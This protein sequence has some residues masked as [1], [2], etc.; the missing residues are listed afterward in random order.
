MTWGH[1]GCGGDTSKVAEQL[2]S[3]VQQIFGTSAAFAALKQG[4]SVVFWRH[5]KDGGDISKVAEEVQVPLEGAQA[6]SAGE[7]AMK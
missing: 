4:G 5:P 3:G 2:Q 1:P 7:P 6:A